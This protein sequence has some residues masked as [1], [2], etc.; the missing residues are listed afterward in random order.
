LLKRNTIKMGAALTICFLENFTSARFGTRML[1]LNVLYDDEEVVP[2]V[3]LF[4]EGIHRANAVS[5]AIFLTW[6]H[7]PMQKNIL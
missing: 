2:V 6:P 4:P 5:L 3:K 7:N 1:S